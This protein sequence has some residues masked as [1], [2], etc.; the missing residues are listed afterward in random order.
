MSRH[1]EDQVARSVSSYI[2]LVEMS[3]GDVRIF[4][5]PYTLMVL[6]IPTMWREQGRVLQIC[7]NRSASGSLVF[8]QWHKNLEVVA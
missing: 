2:L 8:F 7:K 5:S 3:V 6:Q 4:K 1:A